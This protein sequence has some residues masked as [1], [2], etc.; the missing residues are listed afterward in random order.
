MRLDAA[1]GLVAL[2]LRGGDQ[3]GKFSAAAL[4]FGQRTLKRPHPRHRRHFLGRERAHA[5]EFLAEQQFWRRIE[6]ISPR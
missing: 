6:A 3:G 5:A 2:L 4:Q 1:Q